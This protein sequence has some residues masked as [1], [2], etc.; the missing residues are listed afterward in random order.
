MPA[1]GGL[2]RRDRPGQPC[3]GDQDGDNAGRGL[4][5]RGLQRQLPE[6]PRMTK[7]ISIEAIGID[8]RFGSFTAL[9]GVSL[10]VAK[11]S[12]HFLLGEN[13]AGKSTLVKCLLGYYRPD[14]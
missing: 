13:G 12:M 9:D 8:K 7:A 5:C 2:L 3:G 14:S 10:K 6:R 1:A 4:R 11:G